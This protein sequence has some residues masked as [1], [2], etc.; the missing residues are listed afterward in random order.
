ML[1]RASALSISPA[2]CISHKKNSTKFSHKPNQD[3]NMNKAAQ[4]Q[5][6]PSFPRKCWETLIESYQVSRP[7]LCF[8]ASTLYLYKNET[9]NLPMALFCTFILQLSAY[10][11]NVST[12]PFRQYIM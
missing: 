5:A 11:G 6:Q 10:A 4:V 8:V 12:R 3:A 7:S 2:S 9:A 1:Y